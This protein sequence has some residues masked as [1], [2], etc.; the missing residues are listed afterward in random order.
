MN[1]FDNLIV[2]HFCAMKDI[3]NYI[4]R[5]VTGE[6]KTFTTYNRGLAIMH[7]IQSTKKKQNRLKMS[8]EYEQAIQRLQMVNK[9]KSVQ[10][11]Q[12]ANVC[13]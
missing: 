2:F 9:H 13:K 5:R 4:I 10:L 12:Q 6:D 7:H 1:R 3:I 11:Q 8:K